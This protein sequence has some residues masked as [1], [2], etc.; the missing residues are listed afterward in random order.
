MSESADFVA[1]RAVYLNCTLKPS[2]AL[3]HTAGLL[4]VSSEIMRGRGVAV[5]E[6]RAVDHVI[7]AGVQPDMTSTAGPATTGPPSPGGCSRPTSS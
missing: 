7:A 2:P 5:E 6:I 1:L 3:S 4:A